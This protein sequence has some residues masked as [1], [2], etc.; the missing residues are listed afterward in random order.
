MET[1]FPVP[2]I[3]QMVHQFYG[4]IREDQILGPIFARRIHD[5]PVHLSR[6]VLF[7]RAVLR[8]E[9]GFVMSPKGSPPIL[10][11]QI[12][13]L[14]RVHFARWLALF[15]EV[16]NDLFSPDA[17]AEVKHAAARIADSLGRHLPD[18]GPLAT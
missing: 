5:W 2:Q 6:M 10:H 16:V 13:E 17:A 12:E 1:A 8:A 18:E 7:W 15:G 3:E 4:R 14:E 9:R 11:R